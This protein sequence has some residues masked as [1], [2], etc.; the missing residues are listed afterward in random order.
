MLPTQVQRVTHPNFS[1]LRQLKT[2]SLSRL[3]S[4]RATDSHSADDIFIIVTLPINTE[5]MKTEIISYC[6]LPGFTVGKKKVCLSLNSCSSLT[7]LPPLC[8]QG[9]AQSI[10]LL[11][12]ENS[13]NVRDMQ[14]YKMAPKH[15]HLL[16]LRF[17]KALLNGDN[18]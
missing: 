9:L 17:L 5:S 1:T 4:S 8:P 15:S 12:V 14:N 16:P 6:N 11:K 2:C 13:N 18:F 10:L 7:L 3:S